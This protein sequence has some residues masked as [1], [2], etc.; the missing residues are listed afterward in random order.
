LVLIQEFDC[1]GED[2]ARALTDGAD[3]LAIR[4]RAGAAGTIH[5]A[6]GPDPVLLLL[7]RRC[8]GSLGLRSLRRSLCDLLGFAGYGSR[9]LRAAISFARY[10]RGCLGQLKR[11][12][13]CSL[14]GRLNSLLV[15]LRQ[16]HWYLSR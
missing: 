14:L 13:G 6:V 7:L 1:P 9:C 4:R 11:F 12:L 10:L 2:A 5:I 8:L 3:V 15:I 16:L